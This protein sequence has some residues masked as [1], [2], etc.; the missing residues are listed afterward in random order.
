MNYILEKT[1]DGLGSGV[2]NDKWKGFLFVSIRGGQQDTIETHKDNQITLFNPACE[3]ANAEVSLDID[4]TLAYFAMRSIDFDNLPDDKK[5]Q[6]KEIFDKLSE[7]V[8]K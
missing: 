3:Y 8:E 1:V 2:G 4:L 6:H 5:A 7:M